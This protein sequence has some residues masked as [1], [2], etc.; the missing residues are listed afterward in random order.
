MLLGVGFLIKYIIYGLIIY[1][2]WRYFKEKQGQGKGD[3]P[4]NPYTIAQER[5]ARGEIS[6]EEYYQLKEDLDKR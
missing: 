1:W 5:Y 6:R 4:R 3:N 2:V